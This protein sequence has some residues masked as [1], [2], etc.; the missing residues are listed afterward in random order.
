MIRNSIK[1][2]IIVT[3]CLI[4]AFSLLISGGVA[5]YYCFNLLQA[6]FLKDE[7]IN[8]S[9]TARQIEYISD[10]IHK[11]ALNIALDGDVQSYLKSERVSGYEKYS[12]M[13]TTQN[14]IS[15]LEVQRDYMFNIVLVKQNEL[16]ISK[17]QNKNGLDE[18]NYKEVMKQPWYGEISFKESNSVFSGSYVLELTN[19]TEKVIPYIVN[20]RDVYSPDKRIGQLILNINYEYLKGYM[21]SDSKASDDYFWLDSKK[22]YLFQK[23][24]SEKAI[25][26]DEVDKF[27]DMSGVGKS[28]SYKTAN[29]YLIIDRSMKNGWILASYV[30]NTRILGKTQYLLYFFVIYTLIILVFTSLII[31]PI[32]FGITRPLSRLTKA[33]KQVSRGNM[34]VSIEVKGRDELKI[35]GDGFN[36]MLASLKSYIDKTVEYEKEKRDIE[37]SLLMAQINPHFIYNT[38]H[39]VIYMAN[40]T[41]NQDIVDMVKSLIAVLQDTVRISEEG[42]FTSLRNE[43]EAVRQ[44]LNIQQYRYNGR[45]TVTWDIDQELLECKVPR[46]ILQPIVEN[47]LLHGILQGSGKGVISIKAKSNGADMLIFIEDDGTGIEKAVIEKILNSEDNAYLKGKMHSIGM[48]NVLKRIKYICGENYGF[49]IVSV[50][51]EYTRFIIKLP[52]NL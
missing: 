25:S 45:F 46:T 2:K 28:S 37:L 19:G 3:F 8:L 13:Q 31:L 26:R 4:V 16:I 18:T 41:K 11:F 20:V 15:A 9:K 7:T 34:D 38:L 5:Y 21:D 24:L 33:M 43:F 35:L 52:Q 50:K 48:P 39:T 47:S 42:L 44:Y 17:S 27:V 6:Q 32:V 23:D 30:L 22:D 29:G 49:D 40:R 1:S 36:K 51:N 10:D 12:Q 14:K